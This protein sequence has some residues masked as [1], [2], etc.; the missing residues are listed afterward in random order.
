MDRINALV[1]VV[2]NQMEKN[3]MVGITRKKVVNNLRENVY[4]CTALTERG[5]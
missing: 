5:L 2:T 3:A 1:T 4:K